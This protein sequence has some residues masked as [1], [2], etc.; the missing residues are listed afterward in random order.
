[1]SKIVL[2]E[3]I[4]SEAQL[5]ADLAGVSLDAFV[6]EAVKNYLDDSSESLAFVLS[7]DRLSLIKSRLTN[8][9]PENFLSMSDMR[10][11]SSE[12]KEKWLRENPLLSS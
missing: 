9:E 5:A 1:M 2:T 3:Q 12:F 11:R 4:A 10:Q 7:P 8:C 6:S